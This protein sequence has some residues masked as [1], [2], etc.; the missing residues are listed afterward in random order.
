MTLNNIELHIEELVL[1]SFPAKDRHL[2]GE[3]VQR[4]LT[5]LLS[6]RGIPSSLSKGGEIARLNGGSFNVKQ[7]S[8]ADVVGRQVAQAVYGGMKR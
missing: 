8:K 1:H 7:G 5:R 6:E 4:E 3:A 2:V